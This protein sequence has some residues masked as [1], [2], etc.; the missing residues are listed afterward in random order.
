MR[1]VFDAI[2]GSIAAAAALAATS[3]ACAQAVASPSSAS[4]PVPMTAASRA[5]PTRSTAITAA[6]NAK[7]PGNQRPEERVIPQISIPLKSRNVSPLAAT[8][9][10]APAG[11]VPGGVNAG[12][13]RCLAVGDASG[14]AACE[15]AL[16][17]SE[18][19]KPGR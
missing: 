11:R 8:A 12:A 17:A 9:S 7:E 16:V 19:V 2:L 10:S 1:T 4:A 13:A 6:E 15:R 3:A 18:P 5:L 14:R